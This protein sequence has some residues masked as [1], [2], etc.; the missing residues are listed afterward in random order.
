MATSL[1]RAQSAAGW[2]SF[3]CTEQRG[4]G[5]VLG[6]EAFPTDAVEERVFCVDWEAPVRGTADVADEKVVGVARLV[7]GG[8]SG[9]VT[10]GVEV[11]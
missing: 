11:A 2:Q 7:C 6:G 9:V 1:Q 4:A 3:V 10:K 5:K 8:C